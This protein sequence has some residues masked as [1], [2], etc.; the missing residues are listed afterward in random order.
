[1]FGGV[2][3][4]VVCMYSG[5]GRVWRCGVEVHMPDELK[6]VKQK[7]REYCKKEHEKK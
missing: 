4:V 6:I 7:K 5:A 3:F 1:M 2:C